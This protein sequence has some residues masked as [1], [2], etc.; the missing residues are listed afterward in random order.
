M[1]RHTHEIAHMSI[2][3]RGSFTEGFGRQQRPS[4][5]STLVVHPAEEEHEV[6]F[7]QSGARVFSFHIKPQ[8][9]ER[10]R[11]VTHVLDSP[12]AFPGGPPTWLAV[13]LYRESKILDD[14]APL[15]LETLALEIVAATSRC[16]E[17]LDQQSF[18]IWL[19][20]A[21]EYLHAHFSGKIS[22][23]GLADL[24]DVHPVYLAREFRRRF[25]C[26]MSDYVRRLRIESA[27][28]KMRASDLPIDEVALAVGFYDQSHLSNSF[29]RLT[30]TTPAQYRRIFRRL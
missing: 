15:T 14:I 8:L 30:G 24:L 18:P 25:G 20:R 4:E 5:I 27:C 1:P 11:D 17:R 29:K 2:V 19:G 16:A 12:A 3:L 10:I 9:H 28:Q 21:R 7:H 13:T 23:T 26:T 22:C 6:T